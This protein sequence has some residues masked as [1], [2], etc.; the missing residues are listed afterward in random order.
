MVRGGAGG[1]A[2][3]ALRPQQGPRLVRKD[4]DPEGRLQTLHSLPRLWRA[5]PALRF[6]RRIHEHILF[7]PD[8]RSRNSSVWFLH[9]GY[10][11]DS[12]QKAQRNVPILRLAV[13]DDPSDL[14]CAAKLAAHLLEL[15]ATEEAFAILDRL[16][17]EI[18]SHSQEDRPPHPDL[19]TA[20]LAVLQGAFQGRPIRALTAR[21]AVRWYG[22]APMVAWR[23]AELFAKLGRHEVACEALQILA[24]NVRHESVRED[25]PYHPDMVGLPLYLNLALA[26]HHAGKA[27]LARWAYRQVLALDPGHAAARQNLA[28]LGG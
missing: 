21:L 1:A 13:Q 15:D 19:G 4:L 9:D 20:L 7:P 8:T 24:S 16:E 22:N 17:D 10:V 26:A 14:Y 12:K 25:L 27:D 23:L 3:Q 6:V 11:Q 28:A 5:D 18:V 2:P